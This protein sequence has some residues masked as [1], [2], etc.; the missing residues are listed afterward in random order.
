MTTYETLSKATIITM[1]AEETN[2]HRMTGEGG[3]AQDVVKFFFENYHMYPNGFPKDC[4]QELRLEFENAEGAKKA[5]ILGA[6]S[7]GYLTFAEG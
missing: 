6:A 2:Q 3:F 5:I 1:G 4:T 7:N